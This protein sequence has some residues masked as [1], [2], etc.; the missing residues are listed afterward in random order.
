MFFGKIVTKDQSYAFSAEDGSAEH[1]VLSLTNLTLAPSSK[2]LDFL[3]SGRSFP[4]YQKRR[5]RIPSCLTNQGE[6]PS[7]SQYFH[8]PD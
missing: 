1:E 6:T 3:I 5:R 8:H 2:V 7:S 4:L